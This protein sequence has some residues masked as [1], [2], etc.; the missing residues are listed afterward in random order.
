MEMIQVCG[1]NQI[2]SSIN[3]ILSDADVKSKS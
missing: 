1:F 2:K 3:F